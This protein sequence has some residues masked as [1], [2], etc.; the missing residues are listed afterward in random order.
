MS[1]QHDDGVHS[2]SGFAGVH[3][4][5]GGAPHWHDEFGEHLFEDL[6]PEE[7]AARQLDWQKHNVQI[8]TV[9][10]D[11]GS[12]VTK[13]LAIDETGRILASASSEYPCSHPQP[14]WSEQDPELWWRAT[15]ETI[16]AVLHRG[17]LKPEDI[18]GIGL[19]GQMHG[20]VFLDESGNVLRPAL[21]WNDQRTVAECAEITRLFS[22][23][24]SAAVPDVATAQTTP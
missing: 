21:L 12:S 8:V 23:A 20:S 4:H 10:I 15:C 17:G 9:G 19:S 16:R 13:T 7:F 6:S 22:H 14:G 24:S 18:G 3:A 2:H 1:G 11:I 5:E